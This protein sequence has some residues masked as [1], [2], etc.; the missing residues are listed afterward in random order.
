MSDKV[1]LIDGSGYIFRAYYAVHSLSTST[2]FPTNALYGFTKMLM[3]LIDQ[4]GADH[5]LMV[6]DAGKDTFRNEMYSEY[7]ANRSECPEDLVPQMPYFRHISRALGLQVTELVGYEADDIIGTCSKRLTDAGIETVIVS[8]DKDLMQLVDSNVEMWDTMKNKHY[9]SPQV[10]EKFGVTPDKIVELLA[11]MGDSSDN[12]PGVAGVGP[13]TALQLIK[14]YQ[15][16]ENI[17]KS[18]ELIKEDKQIRGRVKVAAAIEENPEILRLSRRLVEIKLDCPVELELD[19]KIVNIESLNTEGMLNAFKRRD[20]NIK[21][22]T[23]LSEHLEFQS[24]LK[25]ILNSAPQEKVEA[26]SNY[27]TIYKED[28]AKFV[29]ELK[30]QKEFSF[31]S[32]TTSLDVLSADI[33]GLSFCWDDEIA[34]YIPVSHFKSLKDQVDIEVLINSLTPVFEDESVKK[35]GQNLKY[36]IGVLAKYGINTKGISFDSMLAAYIVNPEGSGYG[37]SALA[38]K[39]LGLD[40][41]DYSEVT[42]GDKDFNEVSVEDATHYACQDAH[43][44]WLLKDKLLKELEEKDV[45][46]VFKT[47]EVPLLSVLSKMERSG[48]EIDVEFLKKMSVELGEKL[49]VFEK[50]IEELAGEKF[51]L[52]SPKQLGVILFEKLEIP[53]KGIKKTKT[54]YSTNAAM[55]EKLSEYH[56][57]PKKILEYRELYKIKSTYADALP[58]H[59]SEVTNRLHTSFNQTITATGRLSSSNPNLQNI[60][61]ASEEGKKIRKAFVAKE[62]NVLICADYSQIELRILAHISNDKNLIQA[63]LDDEDIHSQT[64]RE[65]LGIPEGYDIDATERRLGKTMNF[66]IVYGMGGFRLAKTLEIPVKM[67]NKYIEDYFEVYSGVRKYFDDLEK[68]LDENGYVSTIYGRKRFLDSIDSSGRDKKFLIRAALNAP[69]QGSAADIIKLAMI[70]IQNRLEEFP[71]LKMLLQIHDELI[72]EVPSELSEKASKLINEEMENVIKLQVPLKVNLEV[73]SNWGDIH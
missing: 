36:D 46:E 65:I 73:G 41:V 28:F 43:Y 42:E 23:E 57:L 38:K 44:V 67:A 31:D 49:E 6:F 22:L 7:K 30:K 15:D 3:R 25:Q 60:P 40:S 9:K 71:E 26:T 56:E 19:K 14:T 32:E 2:G 37:L 61:I 5:M 8:G 50:Q 45:L 11:L 72:F 29:E 63:F 58:E 51:N 64:A 35:I 33:V 48:V 1:Y 17:I 39:Y 59:I 47:I 62:G 34:Y 53:T 70:N 55:L 69:I 16:T 66:G 20:P 12:I 52:N 13:K 10:V 54:G 27:K 24:I 68:T 4:V 21:E 18:T